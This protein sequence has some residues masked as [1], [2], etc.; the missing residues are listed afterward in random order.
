M[1]FSYKGHVN[2]KYILGLWTPI[3]R[4]VKE[5]EIM[6]LKFFLMAEECEH[7]KLLHIFRFIFKTHMGLFGSYPIMHV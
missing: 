4:P 2:F 6:L 5:L 3:L 1:D 7:M